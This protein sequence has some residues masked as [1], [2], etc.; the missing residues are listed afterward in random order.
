MPVYLEF[1]KIKFKDPTTLLKIVVVIHYLLSV[2]GA[3]GSF[4]PFVY[5]F[6]NFVV[7]FLLIWSIYGK[8]DEPLKL[9]IV[10]NMCS[11]ILDALYIVALADDLSGF[12][13]SLSAA[14][15]LI[16]LIFRP[17][18]ILLL[19]KKEEKRNIPIDTENPDR[20]TQTVENYDF[21][22][23]KKNKLVIS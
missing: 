16:H 11:I 15:S 3:I 9:A 7:I 13:N 1:Q 14:A 17:F 19:I 20:E 21:P 8:N 23:F 12:R 6:Y 10:I 5:L 18:S 2:L 4:N 22:T